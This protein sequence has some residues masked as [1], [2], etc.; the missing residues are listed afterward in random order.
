M[1]SIQEPGDIIS[2]AIHN[3]LSSRIN[4]VDFYNFV[5]DWN[6]KIVIEIRPFYPLT[7][8]F[9]GDSIKFK[10]GD[11]KDA[12]IKLRLDLQSMLDIA[13]G[14]EDPLLATQKGILELEGLGDDSENLV[15]FYNIFLDS[16]QKVAKSPNINY[17]EVNKNTK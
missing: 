11:T 14:R 5:H 2:V 17:Y 6:K 3:I 4:D 9:E 1:I 10:V 8:I 13:Y 15:K 16:M 7:V 12:D